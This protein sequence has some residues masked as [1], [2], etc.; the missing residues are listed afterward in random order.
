MPTAFHFDPTL[1][2]DPEMLEERMGVF[3]DLRGVH[4]AIMGPGSI[5]VWYH[6]PVVPLSPPDHIPGPMFE[7]HESREESGQLYNYGISAGADLASVKRSSSMQDDDVVAMQSGLLPLN[8]SEEDDYGGADD[9]TRKVALCF[10]QVS[11]CFFSC[12]IL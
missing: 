11:L 7:A 12:I 5:D 1:F 6:S 9:V 2:E 3:R 4:F 8:A 10:L